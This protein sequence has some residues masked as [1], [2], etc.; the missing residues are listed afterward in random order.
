MGDTPQN[1]EKAAP[2]KLAPAYYFGCRGR[3]AGHFLHA[4]DKRNGKDCWDDY[5][6][7]KSLF[8]GRHVDGGFN[9]KMK[10]LDQGAGAVERVGNWTVLSIDDYS[11]DSRP[12]SH[13]TF[14]LRGEHTF[15]EAWSAAVEWFPSDCARVGRPHEVSRRSARNAESS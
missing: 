5:K 11:I 13:A 2:Y 3:S 12:N 8:G 14:I 7:L 6:R 4:C 1:D 10:P 15:D 9:P